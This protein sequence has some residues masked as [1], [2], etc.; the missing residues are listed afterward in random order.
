MGLGQYGL[1][2]GQQALALL[3]LQGLSKPAGGLTQPGL[4]TQDAVNARLF[5]CF[6][7]W[8][9]ADAMRSLPLHLSSSLQLLRCQS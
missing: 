3:S 4:G 2:G 9:S 6:L 5:L 8:T 1:I 7:L